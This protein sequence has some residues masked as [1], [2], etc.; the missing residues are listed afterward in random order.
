VRLRDPA[1]GKRLGVLEV[2]A[3]PN[4]ASAYV[5][6]GISLLAGLLA[7]QIARR[8]PGFRRRR[9]AEA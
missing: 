3:P 4:G 5:G 6:I 7:A 2:P 1:S 9:Y 8:G